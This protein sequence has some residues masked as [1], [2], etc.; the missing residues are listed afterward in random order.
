MVDF[1]KAVALIEAQAKLDVFAK[2]FKGNHV[3]KHA[4]DRKGNT[5]LHLATAQGCL[6]IVKFLLEQHASVSA[7]N[8]EGQTALHLAA[9]TTDSRLSAALLVEIESMPSKARVA[10]LDAKDAELGRTALHYA[11]KLGS[12]HTVQQLIQAGADADVL[13][14]TKH[15]A[16]RSAAAQGHSAA[17]TVLVAGKA[18]VNIPDAKGVNPLHAAASIGNMEVAAALLIAQ[19]SKAAATACDFK[20]CSVLHYAISSGKPATQLV[21]LLEALLQQGADVNAADDQGISALHQ[22]A[23][24]SPCAV[25]EALLTQDAAVNL[26]D[27]VEGKTPLHFAAERGVQAAVRLLLDKGASAVIADSQGRLPSQLA[28]GK[29][30][31]LLSKEAERQGGSAL[32]HR[33]A[34]PSLSSKSRLSSSLVP[35]AVPFANVTNTPASRAPAAAVSASQDN[36]HA[37][38][39]KGAASRDASRRG[40]QGLENLQEQLQGVMMEGN[41]IQEYVEGDNAAWTEKKSMQKARTSLGNKR[42]QLRELHQM[43]EHAVEEHGREVLQAGMAEEP[44][45]GDRD[46]LKKEMARLRAEA[47]KVPGLQ[48]QLSRSQAALEQWKVNDSVQLDAARDDIS[49]LK[50]QLEA[51]TESAKVAS[52]P[53]KSAQ[54]EL[55][56]AR[57]HLAAQHETS[58]SFQ[59]EL[60]SVRQQL[61]AQ[62]EASQSA[63]AEVASMSQSYRTQHETAQGELASVS[64]ELA[65]QIAR[66]REQ[67]HQMQLKIAELEAQ[68]E[69]QAEQL[70]RAHDESEIATQDNRQLQASQR[71]L[72]LDYD[73]K[74]AAATE[75]ERAIGRAMTTQVESLQR[76]VASLTSLQA[77]NEALTAAVEAKQQEWCQQEQSVKSIEQALNQFQLQENKL[78]R[79]VSELQALQ[80]TTAQ[81]AE[82]LSKKGMQLTADKAAVESTLSLKEEESDSLREENGALRTH[83]LEYESQAAALQNEAAEH[84]RTISAGKAQVKLLQSK[85]KHLEEQIALHDMAGEQHTRQERSAAILD[86]PLWQEDHIGQMHQKWLER[87]QRIRECCLP[88]LDAGADH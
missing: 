2:A 22:A 10:V 47:A 28:S 12:E 6:E 1:D 46:Q 35:D 78:Q 48:E 84:V 7:S 50:Q 77:E 5:L 23:K 44:G 14:K 19:D 56:S 76:Q 42:E 37:I 88:Q 81:R 26:P 17:V 53:C 32:K 59:A 80:H 31:S 72:V 3:L 65:A 38:F 40:S 79:T 39:G 21:P 61:T 43:Q 20:G 64:E 71:Q 87:L 74:L 82:Q 66:S 30:H 18:R 63:Q 25:L 16:L 67:Q 86:W 24:S 41:Q 34:S 15:T 51:Q 27:K 8:Q 69:Q 13:T 36:S 9:L 60:K 57:Q 4:Y 54:A 33:P 75:A 11:A 49:R 68:H 55:K 58:R 45:L 73:K 52:A 83:C 62:R 85:A 70:R 29:T